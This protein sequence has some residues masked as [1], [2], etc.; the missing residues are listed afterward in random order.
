MKNTRQQLQR[1]WRMVG[2]V[3]TL[4]FIVDVLKEILEALL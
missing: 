2:N 3:G 4:Y 1:I